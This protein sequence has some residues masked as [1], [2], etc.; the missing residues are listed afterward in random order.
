MRLAQKYTKI[1]HND[2]SNNDDNNN[3]NN[4]SNNNN[5]KIQCITPN[6]HE[7][8]MQKKHPELTQS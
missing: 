7:F 3:N 1:I 5:N 6:M 4:N 2:D 8:N